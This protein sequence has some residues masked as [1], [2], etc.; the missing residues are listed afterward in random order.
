MEIIKQTKAYTIYKKRNGR[1]AVQG[2]KKAWIRGEDKVKILL[3]EG[4]IQLSQ[5]RVEEEA[6]AEEN[7]QDE[8]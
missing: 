5:P 6:P 3:D 8:S 2:P 7:A 1:H 4:L